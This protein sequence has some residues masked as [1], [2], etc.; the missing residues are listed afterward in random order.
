MT[1]CGPVCNLDLTSTVLYPQ[2]LTEI[3][4]REEHNVAKQGRR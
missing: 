1:D 4:F 3:K 2:Q